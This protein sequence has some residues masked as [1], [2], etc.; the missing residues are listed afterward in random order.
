M[1]PE[2]GKAQK[3]R[4]RRDR[5]SRLDEGI[6]DWMEMLGHPLHRWALGL[7]FIWVGLLKALGYKSATSIIAD[8]IY[9]GSPEVT[10]PFLGVWEAMIGCC[11]IVRPLIRVALAL[12]VIRLPGTL[13]ALF[14][15]P[16]VCFEVFPFVPTIQGQYLIKDAILFA[17]AMVIGGTVR[18]ESAP[19]RH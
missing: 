17:A 3:R 6:A 4:A 14:A 18:E 19:L 16:E 9:F 2:P 7:F 15:H 11:L 8:T 5:L 12:L 10:V 1:H 13:L